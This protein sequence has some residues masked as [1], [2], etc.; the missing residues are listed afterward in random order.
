[1]SAGQVI[2]VS[3]L[4][5]VNNIYNPRQ[6]NK[7]L[8]RVIIQDAELIISRIDPDRAGLL[9]FPA[10]CRGVATL[11]TSD[12]GHRHP[13]EQTSLIRVMECVTISLHDPDSPCNPN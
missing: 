7:T 6:T 2:W 3:L 8:Q 10:F 11:M 4:G 1:M 5:R 13:G 12:I 9:S